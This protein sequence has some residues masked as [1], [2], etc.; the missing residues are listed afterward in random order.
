MARQREVFLGAVC[1]VCFCVSVSLALDTA[2]LSSE[3]TANLFVKQASEIHRQDPLDPMKA[4]QAMTFLD[5][6]V[7]LDS[8]S[9]SIAE[10]VLRVGAGNCYAGADYTD[11]LT[12]AMDRYLHSRGDL[13]VVSRALDCM[14]VGMNTR[15]DREVLLQKLYQKY[16]SLNPVFGSDLAT[17]QGFLAVEK[18]DMPSATNAFMSGYTLNPYNQLA[19]SKYWELTAGTDAVPSPQVQML[20]M[21]A[22]LTIDPYDLNA[23][24]RYAD[25]LMHFQLY[26]TAADAYDYAAKVYQFL[27]PAQQVSDDIVHGWLLGCYHSDR[28]ETKCLEVAESYR[29]P[30][31]LDLMLEAVAGKALIKMGQVDKGRRLLVSAAEKAEA[32]LSAKERTQPIYPEHLAWFYSFVQEE[33]EKALAWSNRAFEESPDRK[34]V[35]EMFAYA[36]AL[37]GQHELAQQYVESPEE[38]TPIALLTTAMVDLT[39]EEQKQTALET[40]RAVVE[41]SPESFVAEKAINLLEEQDSDYIPAVDPA[42]IQDALNG[43]YADRIVPDFMEPSKRYS[44][45]LL[46]NGSDFLYGDEIQPRLVIENTSSDALIISDDG[47]LQGRVRIDAAF[48]GG[49]KVEIPELL[50]TRFRPSGPVLPGEHLSVPLDLNC[51]QLRKLLMT[52]PQAE[53]AIRFTVYLDPV[54][55]ASGRVENRV[56]TTDPVQAK[57]YRRGVTLSRNFLLQR[58]DVLSKGQPGQK[59]QAASLFTG[60]LA[61]GQALRLSRADYKRVQV[62]KELLVDAV[63][64]LLADPDWK[65]RVYTL[66]CLVS[67]SMPLD[68]EMIG[69][70]SDNLNHDKWPVRMMA[71]YLLAKTQPEPF[72]K[73]LDWTSE[74]DGH[75]LNRRMALA[76]GGKEPVSKEPAAEPTE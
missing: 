58:L 35:K 16:A 60:L 76:L 17:Q 53:T 45:K 63:R 8:L 26:E 39:K 5:A 68:G 52:Y 48:E 64:K 32:L 59:Y 57:I 65:I 9:E 29:N 51:G 4:E 70:V 36:L 47:L 69:G 46:F 41:R 12:L 33:P 49:L 74:H 37:N 71:M 30:D 7:S 50:S 24:V 61:E 55:L 19:F 67:L 72:Q 75:H 20:Q 38:K 2:S 1:G 23:A 3:S 34:G 42:G 10:Q 6:A 25:A 62:E 73:V 21:R 11:K 31:R 44:V 66:D 27:Y 28:M 15:M 43:Q 22:V 56:K 54:T 13:E 40:L 18:S 14:L